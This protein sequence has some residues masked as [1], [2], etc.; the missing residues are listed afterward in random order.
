MVFHA[1]EV[2][3]EART[4]LSRLWELDARATTLRRFQR[5]LVAH[6]S[7]RRI[8]ATEAAWR[9]VEAAPIWYRVALHDEPPFPLDLCGADYP[10]EGLNDA[11]RTHLHAKSEALVALWKEDA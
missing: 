1:D 3:A 11:W 2:D 6:L 5:Q 8:T 9:C 4:R 7:D 10:L